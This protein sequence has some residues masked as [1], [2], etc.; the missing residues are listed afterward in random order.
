MVMRTGGDDI[1]A[2]FTERTADYHAAASTVHL[3]ALALAIAAVL[4]VSQPA[5]LSPT[6]VR[7]R[8]R[9]PGGRGD[10]RMTPAGYGGGEL[11]VAADAGGHH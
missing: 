10:L 7:R 1:V 6:P 3:T 2:R 11:I 4:A 8:C 9:G 5:P